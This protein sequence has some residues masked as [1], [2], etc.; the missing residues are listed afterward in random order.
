MYHQ[1]RDEPWM[2]EMV[3]ERGLKML[4]SSATFPTSGVVHPR[5]VVRKFVEIEHGRYDGRARI[6]DEF[7]H[8]SLNLSETADA[9]SEVTASLD[10]FGDQNRRVEMHAEVP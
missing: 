8:I 1:E 5:E 4:R 2:G 3:V 10:L 6:P 7:R 9:S